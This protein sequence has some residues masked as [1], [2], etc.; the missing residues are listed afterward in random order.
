MEDFEK[1]QMKIINL[2]KTQV[3]KKNQLKFFLLL[4]DS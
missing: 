3:L 1:F 4:L 2:K